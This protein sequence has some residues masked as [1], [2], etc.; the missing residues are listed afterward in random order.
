MVTPLFYFVLYI[1]LATGSKGFQYFG[2]Q[3][4]QLAVGDYELPVGSVETAVCYVECRTVRVRGVFHG[5]YVVPAKPLYIVLHAQQTGYD[6]T[7]IA[8][9]AA[10]QR[11]V[12]RTP[13]RIEEFFCR[14]DEIWMR[15]CQGI[16]FIVFACFD[17]F[18][19]CGIGKL[20][21]GGDG[22]DRSYAF[23]DGNAYVVVVHVIEV[24]SE[25]ACEIGFYIFLDQYVVRVFRLLCL[26]SATCQGYG[27]KQYYHLYR[28]SFFLYHSV[29]TGRIFYPREINKFPYTDG[30]NGIFLDWSFY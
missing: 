14:R 8:P 24:P 10:A 23:G 15:V 9:S 20:S 30:Q 13:Y 2:Q 3:Q 29:F 19:P 26:L 12:E 25:R 6:Y 17:L 7:V 11:V 4:P 18:E 21:Q 5:V 16:D 1:A 28:I 22:I 27:E